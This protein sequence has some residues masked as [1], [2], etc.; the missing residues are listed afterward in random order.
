[1]PQGAA[2]LSIFDIAGQLGMNPVRMRSDVG[3]NAHEW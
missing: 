1:M 2:E 3:W